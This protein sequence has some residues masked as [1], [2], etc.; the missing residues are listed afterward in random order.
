MRRLYTALILLSLV[1]GASFMLIK[2]LLA[3]QMGPWTIASLR[4]LLG[5]LFI[6]LMMV[7]L[8]RPFDLKKLNWGGSLLVGIINMALPWALI[9]F[10]ETRLTS[11]MASVLNATTPIWTMLVGLVFF[12]A[13]FGRQQWLGM[14]IAFAG[15]LVLLGINSDTIIAAD[16]IGFAVML[17]ATLCYA[18]G[19]Q[20]ARKLLGGMD[21][22]QISVATLAG[23]WISSTLAALVL[24]SPS[25]ASLASLGSLQVMVSLLGLGVLG[26]GVAY[27]LFNYMLMKGSPEFATSVTY[28]VPATAMVWG[29]ALLGEHIGWNLLGGL[30]L[31]LGGVF[32]ANRRGS[33]GSSGRRAKEGLDRAKQM[34]VHME[35][36]RKKKANETEVAIIEHRITEDRH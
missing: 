19:S 6:V 30:V 9:A 11:S 13:V 3:H 24:E 31:I 25:I 18:I 26:S 22:Y 16:P 35:Q 29:Y 28:L 8:R 7:L 33:V 21:M 32:I 36:R 20:L 34:T 27:I 4:S 10:S 23:A 14:G 12:G 1:W 15:I 17:S 2:V 5:M